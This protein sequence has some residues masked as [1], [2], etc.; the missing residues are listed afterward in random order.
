MY[1]CTTR[2]IA[3][4]SFLFAV[5]N[6]VRA[7]NPSPA[8]PFIMDMVHN[9][10]GEKPYDT[11]YN[12]PGYLTSEGYNGMVPRWFVSCA[13]TYDNFKKN[14]IPQKSEER[15]WIEQEAA[16]ID[17]K[18]AACKKAGIKVYPFSDFIIFPAAVW[19]KYGDSIRYFN[20]IYL[21]IL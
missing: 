12:D 14:T 8:L 4:L 6:I 13:I 7:Q 9:N 21:Q 16:K 20:S 19:K 2:F 17:M 15:K 3:W 1:I 5:Q 18:L 11:K 10:P